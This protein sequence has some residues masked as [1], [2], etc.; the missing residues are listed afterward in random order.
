MA[1][2]PLTAGD[3][4]LTWNP[5]PGGLIHTVMIDSARASSSLLRGDGMIGT[6]EARW[7]GK[8]ISDFE[9]RWT[10]RD[11]ISGRSVVQRQSHGEKR[12]DSLFVTGTAPGVF[13][14]PAGFW[15]VADFGME[16]QLI[17]LI[18]AVSVNAGRQSISVFRPW[19]NRWDT[20]SV[21]V[22]DT[23]DVRTAEL[24]GVNKFHETMVFTVRGNLLCI[25]RYDQI[26]E[27]RPLEGTVRYREYVAR[28]DLLLLLARQVIA[29]PAA[30]NRP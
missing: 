6:A 1:S 19:H 30:P 28:R 9:T 18:R 20:V 12:G 29:R 26:S 8:Q 25:F 4:F 23:I 22:R 24:I 14:V 11:S 5:D 3:T 27:R 15:A 13:A 21:A 7:S 10:T 16:E 2:R 17:P